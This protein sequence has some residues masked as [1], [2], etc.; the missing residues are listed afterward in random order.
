M[1]VFSELLDKGG[2][3]LFPLLS[4][5][6]VAQHAGTQNPV[7]QSFGTGSRHHASAAEG[8]AGRFGF[9]P[10]QLAGLAVE[11]A[12]ALGNEKGF[13]GHMKSRDTQRDVVANAIGGIEGSRGIPGKTKAALL[14]V[15]IPILQ[16]E[17][18]QEQELPGLAS[19]LRTAYGGRR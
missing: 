3:D 13:M 19:G 8:T 6:T 10:S 7:Y 1:S 2:L 15:L 12:E 9:L 17:F 18:A 4:G 5:G 14:N 16:S 11:I